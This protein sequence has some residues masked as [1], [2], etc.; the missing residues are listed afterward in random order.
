MFKPLTNLTNLT[1]LVVTLTLGASALS[2]FA[3][4]D[5]PEGAFRVTP[6][7]LAWKPGRVPGHEIAPVMGDSSK[8]GPYVEHVKF[9]PNSTSQP[10][11]HPESRMYTIISG[12]WY[13][14]Y[15]DTFDPTK[16][17]ALPPGSFYT[18]PANVTHFSQIKDDGVV[19][20]IIGN[21]PTATRFVSALNVKQK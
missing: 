11:S 4:N 12:T 21:G 15:G 13:V 7:E 1:K 3:V 16:L 18:E 2:A 20:Q 6:D 14:G 17:K 5:V 10:H 8:P 9:S 19:V